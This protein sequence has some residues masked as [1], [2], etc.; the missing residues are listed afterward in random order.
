METWAN[1]A[2]IVARGADWF[3]TLGTE[4]SPGTKIFSLTGNVKNTGLLEI[5][6]GLSLGEIVY[7]IGGG[8]RSGE[9]CRAVQIGGPS[10]GC[11]P[12][13]LF[14][15]PVDFD[16]LQGIGAMMG[17]GGMVVL[18]E[19][20]CMVG[21]ARYFLEFTQAESCG[22]CPP[23][24][25]GTR[26]MLEILTRITAGRG[27]S[28]DLGLLEELARGVKESSLCGLGQT[29]P[30]PVLTTLRY[31]RDE[32]AAHLA[33]RCPAGACRDLITYVIDEQLCVGCGLC[34][35]G[36]RQGAIHRA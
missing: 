29:A 20:S 6:M 31:F 32:Y 22:Q 17:S 4:G 12:E 7:G 13:E 19:D 8:P 24:R 30:N 36:C 14:D 1:V 16:S 26:R 5:P 25:I 3:R 10:G 23:C 18:Y 33:G 11:I 35:K 34:A 2:S 28:E 21:V 15:T 9:R 27:R